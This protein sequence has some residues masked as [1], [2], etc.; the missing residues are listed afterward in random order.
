MMS[1]PSDLTEVKW[2][3]IK[4]PFEPIEDIRRIIERW[5]EKLVPHQDASGQ[6]KQPRWSK[7]WEMWQELAQAIHQN[8]QG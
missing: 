4:H 3:K 2:K 1:Y 5:G 8:H 6:V 7:C